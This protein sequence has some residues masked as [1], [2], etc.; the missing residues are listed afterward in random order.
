MVEAY[1]AFW[2]NIFNFSGT[3]NRKSYWWPIIINYLLGNILVWLIS[4][5]MGHPISDV[6]TAGDLAVQLMAMLINFLVWLA[7]LSLKFRRLHDS[8]HSAWWILIQIIPIIGTIW[9]F[10]LMILP[11]KRNRWHENERY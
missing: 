1:S 11:T 9:W 7:T 8:D 5:L 4:N 3:A 10:I 2:H 6:H